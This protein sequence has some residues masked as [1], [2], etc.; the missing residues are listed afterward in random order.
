MTSINLRTRRFCF[1][2]LCLRCFRAF[3]LS[4]HTNLVVIARRCTSWFV[5]GGGGGC[6]LSGFA[7]IVRTG[8]EWKRSREGFDVGRMGHD[9]PTLF[10]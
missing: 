5:D 1:L 6:L 3:G 4:N 8:Q 10:V 7:G 2:R 9:R